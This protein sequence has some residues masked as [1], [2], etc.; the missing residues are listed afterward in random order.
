MFA[1]STEIDLGQ[2]LAYLSLQDR[3]K[4]TLPKPKI[5]NMEGQIGKCTLTPEILS[6]LEV[7]HLIDPYNEMLAELYYIRNPRHK[8]Q[9]QA[10]GEN[11][12]YGQFVQ[13]LFGDRQLWNTGSW[14]HFPWNE[15]LV[16]YLPEE[17]HQE[18]RTSRNNN[19]ISPDEQK[20][21]Y[22][23]PIAIAGLSV[24]QS[25]A[26]TIA[27]TGGSRKMH[28]ADFDVISGTNTG[29]LQATI[30]NIGENKAHFVARRIYEINPYA[31]LKLF[32]Q[33]VND[34]N[35]DEFLSGTRAAV[36]E[37]DHFPT[38]VKLHREGKNRRMPI[39][40]A[41]DLA[42]AAEVHVERYDL[43]PDYPIFHGRLDEDDLQRI[44]A[45]DFGFMDM[46]RIFMKLHRGFEANEVGKSLQNVMTGLM[47]GEIGSPP[48]L[49]STAFMAGS[50]LSYLI[51]RLAN[52]QPVPSGAHRYPDLA[53]YYS[54]L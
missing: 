22:N 6:K 52:D 46:G 34:R 51:R 21:Y 18:L 54:N 23:F 49:G 2:S 10:N 50:H 17:L 16:H 4:D 29:R 11:I 8:N 41:A 47:T 5:F 33:G 35:M 32:P 15:S 53:Q 36:I 42:D 9:Y 26:L 19:L 13:G 30:T 31:K 1:G 48:Q 38:K 25:A 20:A 40:S 24:G 37:V 7:K 39:L 28:L 43:D 45:A 27:I 44:M 12:H 3:R 14:V